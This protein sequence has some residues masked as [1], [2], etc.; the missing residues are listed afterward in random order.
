MTLEITPI[1]ENIGATVTGVSFDSPIGADTAPLLREALARYVVLVFRDQRLTPAQF[2]AAMSILGEPMRQNYS[3]FNLTEFPN[4]GIINYN[5]EQTPADTWHTDTTNRVMPPMATA[6]YA[7]EVPRV[8]GDTSFANMRV[9][10]AALPSQMQRE[11]SGLQTVNTF[12]GQ[13]EVHEQDEKDFGT[14]VTHPL[15]RTHPE[16]GEKALYFHI[17]KTAHIV[18]KTPAESRVLLQDLLDESIRPEFVYRHRW[19]A[20]DLVIVDNR[21]AMH[22]AHDDY[23]RMETRLLHRIVLKGCRP[24]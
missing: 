19:Q 22:K 8:G 21:S 24:F 5:D 17:L 12:D 23:D 4:I 6:L 16:T 7:L 11:L 3:Q 10:Y 14:A 20:G 1:S 15:V 9:A 2:L 13:F 18:G